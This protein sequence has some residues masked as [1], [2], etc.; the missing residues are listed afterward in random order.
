[1][2]LFLECLF[3]L[4]NCMG[5]LF[6]GLV[7]GLKA[8]ARTKPK[9]TLV[10]VEAAH[11]SKGLMRE[12]NRTA[13]WGLLGIPTF[14][15]NTLL[16]SLQPHSIIHVVLQ[17]VILSWQKSGFCFY[18]PIS[19]AKRLGLSENTHPLMSWVESLMW[20]AGSKRWFTQEGEDMQLL[21]PKNSDSP[22]FN[23]VFL[24]LAFFSTWDSR[25]FQNK[26]SLLWNWEGKRVSSEM[27]L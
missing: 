8:F 13:L 1:M 18:F 24:W 9:R 17:N 7:C 12:A 21:V 15:T 2:Q 20:N 26:S 22:T 5:R 11:K 4:L 25:D 16:A 27:K 14:C 6:A 3:F 23:V 10:R 19:P